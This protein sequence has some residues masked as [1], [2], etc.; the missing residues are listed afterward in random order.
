MDMLNKKEVIII[1]VT[2]LILAFSVSFINFSWNVF[3]YALLSVFIILALNIIAKKAMGYYVESD[4]EIKLWEMQR[5]GFKAH[6]Y[7]KKAIPI[8]AILPVLASVITLGHFK[9]LASTVF[10][11]KP[12][13]HRAA[14]RHSLYNFSEMTEYHIGLIA[15]AGVVINLAAA[16]VAY[17]L[18][19]TEFARLN[20]FFASFS[21]IPLSDLDGNKI[22]FGSLTLWAFLATLT[23]IAL[24]YAFLLI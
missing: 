10:E 4:V 13:V 14:K 15:A 7:F 3:L 17:L 21:M 23:L 11:V 18:G 16:V 19:F 12:K 22:F 8:G 9:W 24:A 6:E 2:T 20:I 5:Y 1:I